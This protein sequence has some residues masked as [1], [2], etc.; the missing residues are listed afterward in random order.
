MQLQI[1]IILL[2]MIAAYA[3]ANWRKLSVEICMLSAA[4]AGGLAGAFLNTPPIGDLARHLVEGT[5]TYFDVILVFT[6]ATIFISI[7]SPSLEK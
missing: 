4:I 6:T 1:G 5:F 2:I 7:I 3:V